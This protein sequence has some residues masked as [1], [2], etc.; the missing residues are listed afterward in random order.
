MTMTQTPVSF[1]RTYKDTWSANHRQSVKSG[2]GGGKD[3]VLIIQQGNTMALTTVLCL[4]YLIMEK[5]GEQF[6]FLL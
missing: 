3:K 6:I 5:M 2:L 4:M 1:K